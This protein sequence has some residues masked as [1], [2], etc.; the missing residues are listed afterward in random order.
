MK[1]HHLRIPQFELR[2]AAAFLVVACSIGGVCLFLSSRATAA[3]VPKELT[4]QQFWSLSRDS[5]EEDGFFRSDNLLSNETSFQYIIPELLSVGKTGRVY[6]GVGPEQ[7]FTY[8]SA[9]KPS[10][11][12][13]IDIRH[14]NLDV[15]LLYKA[16]FEVSKDRA[17]FVSKLFSRKRP[18]GLTSRSS[19]SQIFRAYQTAE[20]SRELYEA[21]LKTVEDQLMKKHAFPLSDGDREGIR[22]ALSNYYRFGPAISYNS[23]LSGGIPPAIVGATGGARGGPNNV[24]YGSLMM[25]DDGRGEYRSYLASEESFLFLK[26]LETHNLVIPVVGDFG[27]DKAI[28]AVGRYLKSI[29]ATVSA[30]YLSN[31]EQ[32]LTQDGKWD[33]FCTSVNMLPVDESSVFIRSGRGGPYTQG[34]GGGGVQNSSYAKML[35]ELAPCRAAQR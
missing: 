23:S 28:R 2:L 12:F 6:V 20:G 34:G 22:W 25:S 26:D 7:N 16:L 17:D 8:M 35:P 5:S 13:I 14:G 31:V 30:F 32:F 3:A 29:D 4:D 10:M 27:G 19:V 15:H 33:T 1:Q 9:L 18:D 11:A 24:N 21:N